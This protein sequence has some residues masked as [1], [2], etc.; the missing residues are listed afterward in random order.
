MIA[1]NKLFYFL[2]IKCKEI[3]VDIAFRL[4]KTRKYMVTGNKVP[5]ILKLGHRWRWVV[6]FTNGP[7]HIHG[8]SCL[9][10]LNKSMS[11]FQELAGCFGEEINL[12]PVLWIELQIFDHHTT[13]EV[14]YWLCYP[15]YIITLL[16]VQYGQLPARNFMVSQ[17]ENPTSLRT[18]RPNKLKKNIIH[19]AR[20]SKRNKR[21]V[22]ADICNSYGWIHNLRLSLLMLLI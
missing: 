18:L 12:L 19:R 9:Y 6:D 22:P 7:L 20:T 4:Y 14:T 11:G 21:N 3:K 16:F 13:I 10:T 8:N 17:N 1:T 5:P 2:K 15:S